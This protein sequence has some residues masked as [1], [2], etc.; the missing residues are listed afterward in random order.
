M[1]LAKIRR[2]QKRAEACD[3]GLENGDIGIVEIG[4]GRLGVGRRVRRGRA[5]LRD[6]RRVGALPDG[7][8]AR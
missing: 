7:L 3:L 2:I 5:R 1:Q 4:N 8:V 6:R